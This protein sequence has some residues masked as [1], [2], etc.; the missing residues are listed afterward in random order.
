MELETLHLIAY[1]IWLAS[2]LILLLAMLLKC[3]LLPSIFLVELLR[4]VLYREMLLVMVS[5]QLKFRLP[6][7]LW[8][9][10]HWWSGCYRTT[11]ISLVLL[12]VTEDNPLRAADC[13]MCH[14]VRYINDM[15]L[16][17][18]IKVIKLSI[19]HCTD[20]SNMFK[21]KQLHDC[22]QN[23]WKNC[24]GKN[25]ISEKMAARMCYHFQ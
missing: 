12:L 6:S 5:G 23:C 19:V 8:Q 21:S 2:D 11:G 10:G 18:W 1:S 20:W 13:W 22:D 16:R 4:A 3:I 15:I 24:L 25:C 7:T 14:I 9:S 17:H